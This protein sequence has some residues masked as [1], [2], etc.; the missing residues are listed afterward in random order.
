MKR[1]VVLISL[2][3]FCIL[4]VRSPLYAQASSSHWQGATH[5]E[6]TGNVFN[7]K[8][9][10]LPI[11]CELKN[12]N[13]TKFDTRRSDVVMDLFAN[14]TFE[15]VGEFCHMINGN[16]VF[17]L[18]YTDSWSAP[19][20][21]T[22]YYAKSTNFNELLIG[23]GTTSWFD[24][25]P[26]GSNIA[27]LQRPDGYTSYYTVRIEKNLQS[28][29]KEKIDQYTQKLAVNP[30]TYDQRNSTQFLYADGEK[31]QVQKHVFS[32]NGRY[33]LWGDS[34]HIGLV[35]LATMR[36][37]PVVGRQT[38]P[39]RLGN[40]AVSNDGKYIATVNSGNVLTVFDTRSCETSYEKNE[41]IKPRYQASQSYPG[42]EVAWQN[43]KAFNPADFW[44]GSRQTLRVYFSQN[45][46]SI[47]F[48]RGTWIP[49]SGVNRPKYSWQEYKL[50]ADE[51]VSGAQGYL[52]MGDSYS[53]GEG[54]N[55]GGEWYEPGTDE[56]GDESS[57]QGR[58]LC[59]LSRRSY[60]Y[61]M[62]LEL[63]YL[64]KNT[65][66]PPADGLFHSVACSGAKIHNVGGLLGDRL[67]GGQARDFSIPDNQYLFLESSDISE[68]Q[69]GFTKQF[70]ALTGDTS[71]DENPR[72]FK[73][74][75]ITLGIGGNDAGFGDFLKACFYP[76]NCDPA[77]LNTEASINTARMIASQR[78]RLVRLYSQ[79][80]Q[81][82]PDARVYV[83][84][85]PSFIQSEGGFCA[86]NV[87]LSDQERKT[88]DG[89]TRY[90]NEIVKSAA[91]EA[92][93][94]YVDV[95]NIFDGGKLCDQAQDDQLLVNGVS[96]GNDVTVALPVVGSV[97]IR[98]CFGNE[99]YH[100]NPKGFVKYSAEIL[101]Q[102][103][104]LTKAMP[105]P[106]EQQPIPL[107]SSELFGD[108]AVEAVEH[109]NEGAAEKVSM[110]EMVDSS[111]GELI[112]EQAGLY[113]GAD[114]RV[115]VHS[116]PQLLTSGT[117]DTFGKFTSTLQLPYLEPGYHEIH[118]YS[119]DSQGVKVNYFQQLFV[120]VTTVDFD[121]D[122]IPDVSDSCKLI[123]NALQDADKDGI[124]DS[125]D[126][127]VALLTTEE[128]VEQ[129]NAISNPTRGVSVVPPSPG[130]SEVTTTTL[131]SQ[132]PEQ[133]SSQT[134]GPD[135]PGA[136]EVQAA[137]T[138]GESL[139]DTLAKENKDLMTIVSVPIILTGLAITLVYTK[140]RRPT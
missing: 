69:P 66:S 36:Y 2:L 129:N 28:W 111:K 90:M 82:A 48:S 52:A 46:D 68:W 110:S 117:V 25:A 57:F 31:V 65:E 41:W 72:L 45:G 61:L 88:A 7:D 94:Y 109:M 138:A 116:T 76:G 44:H 54:D 106:G 121:G 47:H 104:G 19:R 13:K 96:I 60:P 15:P 22:R 64:N 40:F 130:L 118:L 112:L 95:T 79:T 56:Q 87:L 18:Q 14:R 115:E 123:Q 11:D 107:P 8:E 137:R 125:C 20:Y 98:K 33:I 58:N 85:Y 1:V 10:S 120:G 70:S 113:P 30:D 39:V 134:T 42:C 5:I 55:R 50:V 23:A 126:A 108:V 86:F 136:G 6:E 122:G 83:H 114:V 21:E 38:E 84:G 17:A 99:T 3:S 135:D 103:N 133:S 132:P 102:T 26:Y 75:V 29:T 73:P 101:K 51:Y 131:A 67:E 32:R 27:L 81:A 127:V 89:A 12:T 71:N 128:S 9:S 140:R 4:Y 24:P 105:A 92:G 124:D 77:T 35:D 80:K 43:S 16:G 37:T 34:Q 49:E 63:G 100:P 59:H 119:H 139:P 53:S 93:V 62:A 97:C 91:Q 74:E 78:N